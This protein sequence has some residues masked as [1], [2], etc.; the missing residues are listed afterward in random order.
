MQSA[1]QLSRHPLPQQAVGHALS[2]EHP[3]PV[4]SAQ[5]VEQLSPQQLRHPALSADILLLTASSVS[6]ALSAV[7]RS[8]DLI[9]EIRIIRAVPLVSDHLGGSP[10][11]ADRTRL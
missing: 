11:Y 3:T 2:A 6:S 5:S 1:E 7:T 8:S 10:I 4:S 9:S